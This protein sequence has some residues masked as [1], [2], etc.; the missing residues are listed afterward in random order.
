MWKFQVFPATQIF[1]EINFG[2]FE[3]P[4]TAVMTIWAAQNLEFLGT[5]DNLK[6]EM[7]KNSKFKASK[8]GKTSSD[9]LKSAKIN[10]T[11]NQSGQ[12]IAQFHTL[13]YPIPN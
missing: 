9:P 11:Q 12:K 4:K 8:I 13:E 2:H 3:A 1:R 10:F 7:Y 5:F 6:R